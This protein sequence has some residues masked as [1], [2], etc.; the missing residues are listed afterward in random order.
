[1]RVSVIVLM[2]ELETKEIFSFLFFSVRP[3]GKPC[4]DEVISIRG[5]HRG[6]A[7]RLL[8]LIVIIPGLKSVSW[9]CSVGSLQLTLYLAFSSS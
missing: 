4:A 1:M 7:L 2:P 8:V 9:K 3:F 6:F 5:C